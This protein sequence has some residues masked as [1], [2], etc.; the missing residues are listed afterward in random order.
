MVSSCPFDLVAYA[1]GIGSGTTR[2][3]AATRLVTT[4]TLLLVRTGYPFP[5]YF[6]GVVYGGPLLY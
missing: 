5:H 4:K 3:H 2:H 1:K 6:V